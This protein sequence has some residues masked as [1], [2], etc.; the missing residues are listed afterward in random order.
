MEKK[1]EVVHLNPITTELSFSILRSGGGVDNINFASPFDL[2]KYLSDEDQDQFIPLQGMIA[3]SIDRRPETKAWKQARTLL[4]DLVHFPRY[5]SKNFDVYHAAARAVYGGKAT[6]EQQAL[7]EGLIAEIEASRVC[8]PIGQT[9]FHGRC[10]R[11]VS[12]QAQYPTFLSTS[13]NPVVARQ[14]A[15]RRAGENFKNGRPVV[16]VLS[17]RCILSAL[18]GQ[19]GGS[20]EYEL[21][22]PPLLKCSERSY[23]QGRKF[24]VVDA[25]LGT[26]TR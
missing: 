6:A 12:N 26:S 18:W 8:V 7:A 15:F 25:E 22:F 1:N 16:Y 19:A 23:H 14:S 21:L 5:R 2:A 4:K 13:L 10:N 11:E 3:K 17:T 24:D 9:L 20:V